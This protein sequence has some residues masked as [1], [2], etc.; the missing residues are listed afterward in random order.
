MVVVSKYE[1]NELKRI[2]KSIDPNAFMIFTEGCDI[3][4]NFEKRLT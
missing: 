4:G 1:V 2:V 3:D